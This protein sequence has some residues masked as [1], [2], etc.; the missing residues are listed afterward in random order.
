MRQVCNGRAWLLRGTADGLGRRLLGRR[1]RLGATEGSCGCWCGRAGG[2]AFAPGLLTT[3]PGAASAPASGAEGAACCCCC[4]GNGSRARGT[5]GGGNSGSCC[6][7][8]T[9]QAGRPA[10][11]AQALKSSNS[12]GGGGGRVCVA[13][14][15]DRPLISTCSWQPSCRAAGV[16]GIAGTP[17]HAKSDGHISAP[18][19]STP[20]AE[21]IATEPPAAAHATT[22]ADVPPETVCAR[23]DGSLLGCIDDLS[24]AQMASAAMPGCCCRIKASR[25]P[26]ICRASEHTRSCIRNLLHQA[27][28]AMR[29]YMC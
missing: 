5:L 13:A 17:G 12:I 29:S 3:P 26:F 9:V 8:A 11:S 16:S 23:C 7:G 28:C 6:S 19:V 22:G 1:L 15:A 14:A 24:T 4:R 2:D 20:V 25:P 27:L 18:L 10:P 21:A